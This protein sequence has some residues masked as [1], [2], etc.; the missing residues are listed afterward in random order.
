M[1]FNPGPIPQEAWLSDGRQMLRFRPIRWDRYAQVME[2]STGELLP[3]QEVP[4]L[5]HRREMRREE[6][7]K[8][9]S[10]KRKEGW[11]VCGPFQPPPPWGP[12]CI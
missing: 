3:E 5:K 1:T 8:L 11:K 12:C 7:R 2:I 10:T 4:L 6:A 9:W